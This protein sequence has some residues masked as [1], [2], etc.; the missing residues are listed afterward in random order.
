M[1]LIKRPRLTEAKLAAVRRNQQRSHGPTAVE[2]RE[3]IR[4]ALLRLGFDLQAEEAAIRALGENPAQFHELLE[5]LW[6][7]HHPVG[8]F[9]EGLVIRL[10]RAIWLLNRADRM[11]EGYS[12]R[13]AQD[14]S[15]GREDR[16]HVQ[17]MRLKMAANTLR[18]LARSV[19]QEN[20]FTPRE[21]LEMMKTLQ[22][23]GM[24][25]EMA[26]I[27][28]D[29]F[30]QLQKPGTD[31]DGVSAEEKTRRVVAKIKAIFGISPDEEHFQNSR[32]ETALPAQAPQQAAGGAPVAPPDGDSTQAQEEEA[33]SLS[34][35]EEAHERARQLLENLLARMADICEAQRRSLRAE[36]RNGPSP[37]ERAAEIAPTHP[38]AAAIRKMEEH[39]LRQIERIQNLLM[40]R[41]R[42]DRQLEAIDR[43]HKVI[44]ERLKRYTRKQRAYISDSKNGE[45]LSR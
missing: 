30:I 37:Y 23:Q 28:L 10:A 43:Q 1:S 21:D 8:A 7:E 38:D 39:S 6:E 12:L 41:E 31:G 14:V 20:Y 3:R 32:K 2:T 35:E 33:A 4:A 15:V 5:G 13:Q 36:S 18:T 19:E 34:P 16:R 40:K 9:Q 17:M 11:Q 26:G 44:D 42:Q 29:L 27:A 45:N 22:Q 25:K 24:V